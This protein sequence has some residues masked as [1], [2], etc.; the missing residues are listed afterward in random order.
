MEKVASEKPVSLTERLKSLA[1]G[2]RREREKNAAEKLEKELTRLGESPYRFYIVLNNAIEQIV[3]VLE[4]HCE[5]RQVQLHNGKIFCARVGIDYPDDG[6]THAPVKLVGWIDDECDEF[7]SASV[8]AKNR[9]QHDCYLRI[10]RELKRRHPDLS[11]E[12]TDTVDEG[13]GEGEYYFKMHVK[14]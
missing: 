4:L 12:L 5:C 9:F 7:A 6:C 14:W 2:R 13:Q 1:E 8:S 10:Y 11:I 3:E